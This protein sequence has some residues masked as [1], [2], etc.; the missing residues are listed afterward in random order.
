MAG[1][2][3]LKSR[4]SEVTLPGMAGPAK[5]LQGDWGP[6]TAAQMRGAVIVPV[7]GDNP[8]GVARKFREGPIQR[9][10]R[11]A[12]MSL[13]QYQA[14]QEI[15]DAW[16]ECEMLSSGGELK[17]HVDTSPNPAS[18]VA[19]QADALSRLNRAV[20]AVPPKHRYVVEWVC[21]DNN[22]IEQLKGP[23]GVHVAN[24][25]ESMDR[26]ADRLGY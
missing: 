5:T 26:V 9:M 13:R 23:Y 8:N 14:A 22:R 18:V 15:S 21:Y 24:F 20:K 10:A 16:C 2:K 19:A 1:R 3:R 7:E 11:L 12:I 25:L 6:R 17:E 4:R